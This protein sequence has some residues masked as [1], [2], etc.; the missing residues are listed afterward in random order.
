MSHF[1]NSVTKRYASAHAQV[2]GRQFV[3]DVMF[4]EDSLKPQYMYICAVRT[5]TSM[6]MPKKSLLRNGLSN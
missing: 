6:R 4:F 5:S 3:H 2:E 1:A